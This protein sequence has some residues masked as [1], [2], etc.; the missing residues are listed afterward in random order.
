MESA[1]PPHAQ[2][3]RQLRQ[4]ASRAS[5]TPSQRIRSPSPGPAAARNG[6]PGRPANHS[7][8]ASAAS[9]IRKSPVAQMREE[10]DELKLKV[11]L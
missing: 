3:N 9:S 8:N 5:L 7:R 6:T 1:L 11:I 2:P 4:P 10:F